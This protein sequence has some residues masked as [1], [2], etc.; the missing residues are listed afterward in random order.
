MDFYDYLRI[1]ATLFIFFSVL[2][3]WIMVLW[4]YAKE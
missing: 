1:T 2:G 3:F 4:R